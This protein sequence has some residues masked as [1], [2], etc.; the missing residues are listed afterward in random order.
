VRGN[1]SERLRHA[2]MNCQ[3]LPLAGFPAVH[4]VGSAVTPI[5]FQTLAPTASPASP[6]RPHSSRSPTRR[7]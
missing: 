5:G 3:T 7:A 6:A 4:A 2:L 1:C